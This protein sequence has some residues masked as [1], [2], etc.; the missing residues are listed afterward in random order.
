[1]RAGDKKAAVFLLLVHVVLFIAVFTR[2]FSE[3]GRTQQHS[4]RQK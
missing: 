1:M 4:T 2:V 3:L